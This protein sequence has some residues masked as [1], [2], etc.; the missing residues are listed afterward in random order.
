VRKPSKPLTIV[1]EINAAPIYSE[2]MPTRVLERG[3]GRFVIET[4]FTAQHLN[5]V[6][7][8]HGGMLSALLDTGLA[9][10]AAASLNDGHGSYGVTISMTVNFVRECRAGRVRCEAE[11]Q[12]GGKRTKFV[13]ARLLDGE[14]GPVATATVRVV[15]LER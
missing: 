2:H 11:I 1:N 13:N 3:G 4:E 9:G 12:G 8:V 10:G 15:T 5:A 14:P 6:G 7:A